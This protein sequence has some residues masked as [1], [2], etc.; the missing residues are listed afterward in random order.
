M[1]EKLSPHFIDLIRDA[2]L[3]SFWRH[4]ALVSFLR[5]MHVAEKTLATFGKGETKRK[6]LDRLFP[7]LEKHAKGA[8]VL[9]EMASALA[10]QTTFPDLAGWENSIQLVAAANQAVGALKDY[11]K[12]KKKE[13]DDERSAAERRKDA[14][15]ARTEKL[16]SIVELESLKTRLETLTLKLGTQA[17]GYEFQTWF[18]D[19]MDYF[20]VVNRRPYVADGRQIDGSVTIDGTTYLIELKFTTGQSDAPDIDSLVAKVNSKADNTMGILVSI[21]GYSSVAIKQASSARSPLLL[22]DHSHVFYVLMGSGTF[23]EV[24]TRIRRHSAQEGKAYL[25]VVKFGG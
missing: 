17:G 14:T 4:D 7:E 5:R 6:W 2:L 23:P 1:P 11:L 25:P 3:K 18:Y 16:R 9:S 12:R 13:L 8:A 22:I 19:L 10:D 24:I 20:D 21:S 15:A